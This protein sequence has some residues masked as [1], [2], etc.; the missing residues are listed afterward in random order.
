MT[1][2]STD[3]PERGLLTVVVPMPPSYRGGT[4]EYAYQVARHCSARRPVHIVTTSVR[5]DGGQN[6][7]SIGSATMD[8]LPA[9]EVLARPVVTGRT[10]WSRLRAAV[11]RAAVVQLHMPFPRVEG[12]VTRW[13][14]RAHIPVALTYHMDAEFGENPRALRALLVGGAYR[15]WSALPALRRANAVV[16]NSLGYARASPVLSRFLP[17]VRVIQQGVDLDRLRSSGPAPP[18]SVPPRSPGVARVLFVG[19]IVPYKG[20]PY[21]IEAVGQRVQAGHPLEL[22]IGGRGPQLDELKAQVA[23]AGLGGAVR[24]L[25]FVPDAA[26]G[27][28]YADADVVACPSVSLL[29]STPIT[30]QE[31]M[32]FGTP[33]L[34]TTLPGTEETVPNDGVRGR[35][36]PPME[37]SALAQ[38]IGELTSRPRPTGATLARSWSDTAE[39][40]LQLFSELEQQ[41]PR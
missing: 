41:G 20:L 34:G 2:R 3:P 19:R 33:V 23:R 24:F 29:E 37:A 12:R 4:E 32:A 22:L 36:V 38:A 11:E 15:R 13:A 10:A 1:D 26:I 16:S 14:S 27:A 7:L 5:W 40:Y 9:R 35:L 39:A 28:L 6:A 18:G 21:L 8:R 17:K 30:L 25:G 31:A